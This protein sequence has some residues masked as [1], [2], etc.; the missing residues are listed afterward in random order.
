MLQYNEHV[1]ELAA[2][3]SLQLQDIVK[4]QINFLK[5]KNKSSK[6]QV[7][8]LELESSMMDRQLESMSNTVMYGMQNQLSSDYRKLQLRMEKKIKQLQSENDKLSV[9]SS[10][11]II[12]TNEHKSKFEDQLRLLQ[13][14][15][16]QLDNQYSRTAMFKPLEDD[17]ETVSIG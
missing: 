12:R 6:Q 5:D 17:S 7:K 8:S 4:T 13:K 9:E 10:K 11:K 1:L 16:D 15:I 2:E 3:K 14:Y